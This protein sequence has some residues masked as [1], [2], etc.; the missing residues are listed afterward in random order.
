[1]ADA[2]ITYASYLPGSV[3]SGAANSSQVAS[4]HF[5]GCLTV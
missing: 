4:D 1:M 3:P 5:V 2:E